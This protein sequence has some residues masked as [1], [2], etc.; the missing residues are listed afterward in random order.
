MH[1]AQA[2]LV[3]HS[4]AAAVLTP[5]PGDLGRVS[6][7]PSTDPSS[8]PHKESEGLH[9]FFQERNSLNPYDSKWL[10]TFWDRINQ[11][12]SLRSWQGLK[13]DSDVD[14]LGSLKNIA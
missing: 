10:Y 11:F 14:Y 1:R 4:I 2:F 9:L 8:F 12:T 6:F 13:Y 5:H 7:L 3:G